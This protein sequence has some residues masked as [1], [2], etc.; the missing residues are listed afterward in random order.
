MYY[1]VFTTWPRRSLPFNIVAF[2]CVTS[3]FE[4]GENRSFLLFHR[5][6]LASRWRSVY[7]IHTCPGPR[8]VNGLWA[9]MFFHKSASDSGRSSTNC[10]RESIFVSHGVSNNFLRL[11]RFSTIHSVCSIRN[12]WICQPV[13]DLR[14]SIVVA[15]DRCLVFKK[16]TSFCCLFTNFF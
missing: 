10:A 11:T 5:L 7:S 8:G 12:V 1:H 16:I 9:D 15:C 6:L 13:S 3:E 14:F 4:T 2:F